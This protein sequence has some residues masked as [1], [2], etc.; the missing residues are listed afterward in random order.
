MPTQQTLAKLKTVERDVLGREF[1]VVALYCDVDPLGDTVA[2]ALVTFDTLDTPAWL[3]SSEW[4]PGQMWV[5]SDTPVFA[6]ALVGPGG[7]DVTLDRATTY[8]VKARIT[9][10]PE[11]PVI[12]CYKLK[13]V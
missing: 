4:V 9:D 12:P 1:V 10:D 5:D 8:T 3:A 7:G 2:V 6:R 13:G 11:A